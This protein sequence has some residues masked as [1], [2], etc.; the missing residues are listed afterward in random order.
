MRRFQLGLLASLLPAFVLSLVLAGCSGGDKDKTTSTDSGKAAKDGGKDGGKAT[1][2]AEPLEGGTGVVKGKVTVKV[3]DNLKTI[4]AKDNKDKMKIA[5]IPASDQEVCL[6]GDMMEQAWKVDEQGDVANVFVWLAPP[7]DKFFAVDPAK[8]KLPETVTIDQPH[9]A[10]EPHAAWIMASYKD[11]EG[12]THPSK[13]KLIVK[14]SA[15]MG[16]NTKW[17]DE[18]GT[19]GDNQTLAPGKEMVLDIKPTKEPIAV[20]CSIHTWMNGWVRVFDHPYAA[21]TDKQ[22]NYK[23]EGVPTGTKLNI[24][25]WH[26]AA[27]LITGKTGDE[28]EVKD[29]ENEKNFAI[30]AGNVK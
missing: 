17:A 23:I 10:F 13:Q 28:I 27:G 15:P 12:K 9:C 5:N 25:A 7:K 6:K 1:G 29:G 24:I 22:G 26:E 3:D 20:S 19:Q 18:S 11:K 4:L 14:N 30:P 2:K 8:L 16:H 21:I